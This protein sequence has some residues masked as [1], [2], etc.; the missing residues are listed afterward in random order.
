MNRMQPDEVLVLFPIGGGPAMRDLEQHATAALGRRCIIVRRGSRD[1]PAAWA[2]LPSPIKH[3]LDDSDLEGKAE[4]LQDVPPG[5]REALESEI[6][7]AVRAGGAD[8]NIAVL[9]VIYHSRLCAMDIQEELQRRNLNWNAQTVRS[10]AFGEGFEQCAMTW[11][12]MLVPYLGLAR[13]AEN[14]FKLS[15]SGAPFLAD[16]KLQ[17][18][19]AL[20]EDI[21][22]YLWV[23]NTGQ[24]IGMYARVVPTGRPSG[25]RPCARL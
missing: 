20:S 12:Q 3:F 5:V 23:G 16:A 11:K 18:R 21:R 4:F 22:L 1:P 10:E 6:R 19:V 14:V 15:V 9:E 13:P 17:E 8:W 24:K 7:Q 25:V 2:A